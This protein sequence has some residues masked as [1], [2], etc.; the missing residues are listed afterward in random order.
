VPWLSQEMPYGMLEFVI[1][2]CNGYI[3]SIGQEV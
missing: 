1:F 3:P 2:D